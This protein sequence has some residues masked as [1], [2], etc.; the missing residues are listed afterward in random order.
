M[1]GFLTAG[2]NIGGKILRRLAAVHKPFVRQARRA[3]RL[4]DQAADVAIEARVLRDIADAARGTDPIVAGPWLSEVGFEVLYWIPF[5]RWFKDRYRLSSDRLIAVS[6]GGAAGWYADL[7]GRYVEILDLM[8]PAT[9]AERNAARRSEE[10]GGQK[11][12]RLTPLD[13]ELLRLVRARVGAPRVNVCHPSLM[14]RLFQQFWFGNRALDIVMTHAQFASA[15]PEAGVVDLSS[16]P[17]PFTAVKFYTGTAIP[18][19]PEYREMLMTLVERL[20]RERAVVLLDTGLELDEHRDYAFERVANVVSLRGLLTPRN[21][22]AVQTQAIAEAA[23]FVGTCGSL[24]WLAPMLGVPTVAVYADDRLLAS[25]LYVA[26]QAYRITGA[27]DFQPLDLHAAAA[28]GSIE[29]TLSAVN[30]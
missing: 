3:S 9:F 18:D 4:R 28:L 5:L 17:R 10:T 16:L 23:A 21:N 25:H 29:A 13:E 6:R 27:A 15:R 24:A 2:R 14:Y 19:T 1:S 12:L 11:Q 26:R 20:A 7:A 30:R 8:P 22:L